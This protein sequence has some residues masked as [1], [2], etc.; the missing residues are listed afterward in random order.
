MHGE[1]TLH[2]PD[3]ESLRAYYEAKYA[4]G[5]Y[6]GL[7]TSGF[8]VSA[9]YHHARLNFARNAIIRARPQS[10]LDA[11]CGAGLLAIS[12]AGHVH[13]ITGVDIAGNAFP[14]EI[15]PGVRFL[16][17]NIENLAFSDESFDTV[18]S[19]ETLEHVL[20][21]IRALREMR[22]VLR[23]KGTLVLTYPT[24]NRTAAK[25]LWLGRRT[26]IS[27][28]LT[29]WS[30]K[31]LLSNCVDAG[32]V[33]ENIEGIAFDFGYLNVLKFAG[34]AAARAMTEWSLR[35]RGYANNSLFLGLTLKR[36]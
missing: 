8:D 36:V 29:E 2:F 23:P 28:H 31:E 18:V 34:P 14:R 19:V 11:G 21:P 17:M 22:R 3:N 5:G 20:D 30:L 27:E 13:E 16:Q 25:R 10:L 9:A 7:R 24:I 32:L 12:L 15:H 35:I 26:N 1:P 4:A 33:V 6:E